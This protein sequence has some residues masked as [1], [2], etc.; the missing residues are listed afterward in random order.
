[1]T[2]ARRA[3]RLLLILA[4]IANYLSCL[5]TAEIVPTL[6][7]QME[8]SGFVIRHPRR[9]LLIDRLIGREF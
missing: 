4:G 9:R 5:R 3:E 8:H 1:M 2:R 6:G 7:F